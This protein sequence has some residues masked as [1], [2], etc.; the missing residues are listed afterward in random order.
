MIHMLDIGIGIDGEMGLFTRKEI[1][2]IT[3]VFEYNL[4]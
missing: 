1:N 2:W 4:E 3:M